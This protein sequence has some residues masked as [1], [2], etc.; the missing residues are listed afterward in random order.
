MKH[1]IR[2][3]Y[4][5]YNSS[6]VLIYLNETITEDYIPTDVDEGVELE[7]RTAYEYEGTLSDGGTLIDCS[8]ITKDNLINGIIRTKYSQ[9]DEDAIKTHRLQSLGDELDSETLAEYADEWRTFNTWRE[10]A[11]T[12]VTAWLE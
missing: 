10:Y 12:I 6:Q 5:R 7:P 2:R 8:E 1:Y 11:K 4:Q 9:S 3:T